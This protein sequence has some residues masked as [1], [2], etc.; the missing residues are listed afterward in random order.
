M[1]RQVQGGTVPVVG[2]GG[3]RD[4]GSKQ[5]PRHQSK[6]T[7]SKRLLLRGKRLEAVAAKEAE[8]VPTPATEAGTR[9]TNAAADL[10]PAAKLP[11]AGVLYGRTE[12]LST[13][14]AASSIRVLLAGVFPLARMALG[15]AALVQPCPAAGQVPAA[16]HPGDH[17]LAGVSSAKASEDSPGNPATA[18]PCGCGCGR[19]GPAL[20]VLPPPKPSARPVASG[21]A[22]GAAWC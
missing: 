15:F 22:F 17:H 18:V 4:L 14:K 16:A 19:S 11:P 20:G 3:W 13:G 12:R 8:R 7:G 9:I 5:A 10:P 2:R 21:L 1:A 6:L